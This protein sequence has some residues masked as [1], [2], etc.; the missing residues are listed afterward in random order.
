MEGEWEGREKDSETGPRFFWTPEEEP[1]LTDLSQ[2]T[3]STQGDCVEED[4]L[5]FGG[6]RGGPSPMQK[7]VKGLFLVTFGSNSA[8][9]KVAPRGTLLQEC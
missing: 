2:T 5:F 9:G 1:S 8:L 6:L 4:S 3:S 7:S